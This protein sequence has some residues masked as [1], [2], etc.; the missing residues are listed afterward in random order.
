MIA[1]LRELAEQ[2]EA[3]APSPW[4]V[5][6]GH[7][8]YYI[9]VRPVHTGARRPVGT[10]ATACEFKSADGRLVVDYIAACSPANIL[11]LIAVAEA[12]ERVADRWRHHGA[13][14]TDTA[15]LSAAIDALRKGDGA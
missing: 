12:A 3:D 1:K 7:P 4:E 5:D 13:N 6:D 8:A 14:A 11:R 2:M 15:A 9:G 10:F